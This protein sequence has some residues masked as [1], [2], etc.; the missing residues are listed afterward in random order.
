MLLA[1]ARI[2]A[3]ALERTCWKGSSAPSEPA[4]ALSARLRMSAGREV[5][6]REPS[7]F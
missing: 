2:S 3:S 5:H 6:L 4:V 1:E 7:W